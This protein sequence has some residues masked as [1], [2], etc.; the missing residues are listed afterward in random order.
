MSIVL[1]RVEGAVRYRRKETLNYGQARHRPGFGAAGQAINESG[2]A[3]APIVVS[4]HGTVL[5]GALISEQRYS[6]ELVGG[7]PP[8]ER[9]GAVLRLLGKEYTKDAEADWQAPTPAGDG[10]P[11]RRRN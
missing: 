11:G 2:Q 5:N 8:D 10:Y 4:V 7:N 6:S 3:A 1:S 9:P